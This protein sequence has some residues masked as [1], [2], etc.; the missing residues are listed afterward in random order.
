MKAV[1]IQ[2][3]GADGN[4][5]YGDFETPKPGPGEFLIR[6]A[7]AAVNPVD[8]K[9]CEGLGEM[10][11]LRPPFVV[12]CEIAGTIVD[13]VP[14]G[15]RFIAGDQVYAYLGSQTGGFAEYAV[16]T[17][18]Q[19]SAVPRNLDLPASAS[20]PVGG[21]TAWQAMFD[22]ASLQD[23]QTILIHAASGGVG[24]M[25]VQLAKAR[26]AR[27]FATASSANRA[28]VE[29]LGADRF[30]DYQNEDFTEV[31][32]G[33]DVVFDNIGGET[34]TRSFHCLKKGGFLVSTVRP[35]S[36]EL[37]DR[38]GVGTAMVIVK[39]DS[40]G[41]FEITKL[42]ESGKVRST[43][44]VVFSLRDFHKAF[45]RSKTGHQRGKIVLLI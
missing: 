8:W 12:G 4:V 40:A 3:Y 18:N 25:A 1:F 24:S 9:I 7:A 39:P 38:Y 23:G 5:H 10:F 45:D 36:L 16:A 21:L 27:V 19:L 42:V 22:L 26:G 20:V 17:A 43:T 15:G 31:A 6:V 44:E 41:L 37:G 35:P 33:V 2:A 30:I 11:G 13:P 34:Q 32:S 14:E 29:S 28:F